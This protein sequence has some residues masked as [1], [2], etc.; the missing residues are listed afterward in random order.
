MWLCSKA[1]KDLQNGTT[2][3][4][5]RQTTAKIWDSPQPSPPEWHREKIIAEVLRLLG[6]YQCGLSL[7]PNISPSKNNELTWYPLVVG[8]GSLYKIVTKL[9]TTAWVWR[10]LQVLSRKVRG[11]LIIKSFMCHASNIRSKKFKQMIICDALF[12]NLYMTWMYVCM[13]VCIS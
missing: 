7:H 10:P 5:L 3:V 6:L 9:K 2:T 11:D 4:N 13:Y 12:S 1:A 8:E